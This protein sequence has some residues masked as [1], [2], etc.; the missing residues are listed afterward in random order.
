VNRLDSILAPAQGYFE[1]G[2]F[3]DAWEELD[4]LEPKAK[5]HPDVLLLRLDILLALSRWEDVVTMGIGCCSTWCDFDGFFLKTARAL[6][7]LNDFGHAYNLLKNA[8]ESLHALPEYH[9]EVA[10]CAAK[11]GLRS[12]ARN[13][14]QECFNR[15]KSYRLRVLD[16]PDFEAVFG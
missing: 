14:L 3:N 15:D 8:P 7:H 1:L 6:I 13:A 5:A 11:Q 10:R 12:E 2:L 9:H 16:D 4:K